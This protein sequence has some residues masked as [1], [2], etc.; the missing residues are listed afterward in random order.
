M[1]KKQLA[2]LISV[3]G[4]QCYELMVN[5]ASPKKP[6]EYTFKELVALLQ[7]HLNPKPSIMAERY[8]FRLRRQRVGE[9]ISQY[10]AELKKLARTCEFKE[11]LMDNLRDQFVCGVSG[12]IIRQRLMIAVMRQLSRSAASISGVQER[13]LSQ[14]G[15]CIA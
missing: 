13:G 2:T 10:T 4:D 12:D 8:R 7:K 15:R 14:R 5:L 9:T 3:V 11:T 6:S 1:K